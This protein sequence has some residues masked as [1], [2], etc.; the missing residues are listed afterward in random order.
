L[1]DRRF[2]DYLRCPL[3]RSARL[4]AHDDALVCSRCK[5]AFPVQD[6][7]PCL[8]PEEAA[9]PPGCARL[10]DLPCKKEGPPS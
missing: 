7:I 3:D 6:G 4:E 10:E 9:L 5:L 1:I 2:L 8:L